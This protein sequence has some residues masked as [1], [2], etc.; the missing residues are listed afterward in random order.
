MVRK[1]APAVVC[2]AVLLFAIQLATAT[3]TLHVNEAKIKVLLDDKQSRVSLELDNATG[4]SFDAAF[5]IELLDPKDAVRA[6]ATIRERIGPGRST[7]VVPALLPYSAL[8]ESERREFPWYRL[9]YRITPDAAAG[10]PSPAEGVVSISEVTPALFEM[11]V[12]SSRYVRPGA[13]YRA[14]VRAANPVT[15]RGVR[16]VAVEAEMK[17]DDATESVAL[18]AR[19]VTDADGYVKLDFALPRKIGDDG[20]GELKV[21]GRRG[22]IEQKAESE[23]SSNLKPRALL[24]TDKSLYQP[25]QVLHARALVFD[26]SERALPDAEVILKIEDEEGTGVFIS[27]LKTSRF[28]VA[29]A[30]WQIP[31]NARLG[32]YV[33][34]LK[35]EDD[36]WYT[37]GQPSQTVKVS[38]YDLP[39]FAVTTKADRAFYLGGQNAA[40][41]V[42]ADYLFG[43][44]VKRGHVRVVRQTE[45]SWNY[46]EQK[47][48]TEERAPVEGELDAGGRFV[49]QLDLA[50]EHKEL[51]ESGWKRFDDLEYAAYVTDPTTNRT[52]QRRF[53][54]RLTREPIHV[55]V[56]G[57]RYRQA[58]GLP[59]AFY[60]STSYAD[61]TP[62][63]CEVS[64]VEEGSKRLVY[65]PELPAYEV[66]DPDRSLLKIRTNRYGV[67]KVVGPVVRRDGAGSGNLSLHFNARDGEG[68][69]GHFADDFWLR[70][71]GWPEIRVETDKT[72]YREGEPVLVE[73]TSNRP[74]LS[75]IVDASAGDRVVTS[76]T[77]RLSSGRASFVLPYSEEFKG[78][79]SVSAL[80]T[81]TPRDGYHDYSVGTR[82]IVYPRDRELKLDARLS[83]ASFK[84]GEEA[85]VQFAV[86]APGGRRVE[87]ALGVVVF[88]KAV[89]ERAR[90]DGEFSSAWGFGGSFRSFSY[91]D[92]ELAGIT[93]RQVEQLDA[94]AS[95]APGLE[96]VAEMLLNGDRDDYGPHVFGATEFESDQ[97]EVFKGLVGT[98]L[99]PVQN[100]LRAHYEQQADYPSSAATLDAI[101]S[102][103]GLGFAGMRD[104]WGSPYLTRF[105]VERAEDVLEIVSAGADEKVGTD[106]DFTAAHLSTSKLCATAGAVPMRSSSA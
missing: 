19:G 38:R 75:V 14:R 90:T 28:G 24:T 66:K 10:A 46:R 39:N 25:G 58:A 80:T 51:A 89:E 45:R 101:L 78:I 29:S 57:G 41:E 6:T 31:A 94:S 96:E 83:Q 12:V 2:L 93:R 100:A 37:Q 23:V 30:D 86:R 4:R 40:V 79:V 26:G 84:P 22:G 70:D 34:G 76:Q 81:E 35:S 56:N 82:T 103:A 36:D 77:V 88:D 102:A 85:G 18:K 11:R 55:Y 68:R 13:L 16:D 71:R 7:V 59:L 91:G 64:V 42:R 3:Q 72:I 97:S 99:K 69:A 98:Q 54:L 53:S 20:D 5:Q 32:R 21:T 95:R 43:Q 27:T 87:S 92:A 63:E 48:E 105:S 52:E 104:P 15:Q 1:C 33:V 49:A 106:D 47:Y 44:P 65:R 74:R 9:R 50:G 17:F 8:R 60:V 62:A 61:G 73:V 67:A